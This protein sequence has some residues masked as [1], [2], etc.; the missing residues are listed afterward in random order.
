MTRSFLFRLFNTRLISSRPW[1]LHTTTHLLTFRSNSILRSIKFTSDMI[2]TRSWSSICYSI[3][4]LRVSS[5]L[6]SSNSHFSSYPLL[7]WVISSRSWCVIKTHSASLFS[8]NSLIFICSPFF[9]IVSTWT[10][11]S[12]ICSCLWSFSRLY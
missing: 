12:V 9:R 11:I 3:R 5:S 2:I 4:L 8:T 7:F 10:G 1:N 6:T